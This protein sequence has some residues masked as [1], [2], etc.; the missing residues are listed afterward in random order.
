MRT[1]TLLARSLSWYWR[2]NLA[3]LLG[4]A[5]AAGVLGGAA[6]VGDSVRASLRGLV[7]A[8]LG[9]ADF[10][11]TRSGFFR[12]ELAAA[13]QP[14]TPLIAM[15]A[16]VAH[17]ASGRRAAGVQAYGVDQRFWQF[18]GEPGQPPGGR[19]IL[20][21]AALAGEL[22]ARA[23]DVI[24][25]SVQKPSAIPLETLHGRK[26]DLGKTIRLNVSG[27]AGREF[28]L[29]PQQGEVRAVYVPLAVLQRELNQPGKVNTI[30]VGGL[31]GG[32]PEAGGSKRILKE[33]YS[34]ADLG[35][36]LRVLEKPGC[37]SLE[38]DSALINDPLADAASS[39]AQSLGLR[40]E[41]LLTYL[42]NSIRSTGRAI[43]YS[44][45]TALDSELAPADDDGITLNEWAAR[46]LGAKAG[47]PVALDY[48]VWKSDG[49]LHTGTAQF[50]VEQ[51]V[52]LAGEAADR[53]FAPDYPGITASHSLRDW[54]PPFP[55][56]LS[57]IRPAD[58]RYWEQYRTTP[59]A[60]IRLARG[61]QLWGTRFGSLTSVRIF[62]PV[63]RIGR[64]ASLRSRLGRTPVSRRL[65]R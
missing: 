51:I 57:R 24:L 16:V 49:R 35:L 7:L 26:E 62:P 2:T 55:L 37:L 43:P 39:T 47:D 14:S 22:G 54:D 3:V 11:V 48:Y 61:R 20:L 33:R 21:T 59:K 45:V 15:E 40:A 53:N 63:M 29:R 50:D 13:V 44:L 58:E 10:A 27:V 65:G 31:V 52:P 28:A 60:F 64:R 36:G 32:S 9:N 19:E 23:N 30:L 41:P 18:Q 4:V 6:L 8:R 42:A 56:D 12:E 46:E 38:S 17:E 5:T 25:L 1:S 34:L